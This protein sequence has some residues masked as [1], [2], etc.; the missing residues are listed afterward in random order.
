MDENRYQDTG[1]QNT[2]NETEPMSDPDSRERKPVMARQPRAKRKKERARLKE[3]QRMKEA[4]EAEKKAERLKMTAQE[5]EILALQEEAKRVVG[6]IHE[7]RSSISSPEVGTQIDRLELL[8]GR[9]YDEVGE[10]PENMSQAKRMSEYYLPYIMKLIRAYGDLEAEPVQSAN[11][12]KTRAEIAASF[13]KVNQSLETM[14]DD[15]FQGMAMDVSSDIKVL[16]TL[17][18]KDGWGPE[19]LHSEEDKSDFILK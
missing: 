19:V 6:E 8:I 1:K 7:V 10:H 4:A 17:L 9:I 13:E 14:Y 16:E 2:E 15:L 5:K 3:E 18:K 11:I 12:K